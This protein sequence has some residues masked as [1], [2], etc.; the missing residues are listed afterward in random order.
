[1]IRFIGEEDVRGS[2]EMQ[3]ME[4]DMVIKQESAREEREAGATGLEENTT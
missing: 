4:H 2:E 3:H 1:M